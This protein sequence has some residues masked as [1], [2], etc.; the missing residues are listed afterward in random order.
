MAQIGLGSNSLLD[1]VVF[2][3]AAAKRAAEIVSPNSSHQKISKELINPI[4]S[5]IEKIRN[6]NG[7][8]SVAGLRLKMQKI[9]QNH[10]GVFRNEENLAKGKYLISEVKSQFNDIKI[11]DRSMLWNTDLVEALELSNLIDQ[12]VMTIHCAYNRKESRGAHARDE[13]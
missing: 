8:I 4:L 9:M 10:A 6:A 13:F 1:I 7:N 3:R 12:A 5:R 2:G 11:K